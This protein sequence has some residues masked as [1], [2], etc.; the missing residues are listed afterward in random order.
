MARALRLGGYVR[1][2]RLG[3]RTLE[4]WEAGEGRRQQEDIYAYAKRQ[5]HEVVRVWE[6]PN[7]S[8]GKADRRQLREVIAAIQAG[9]IDGLVVAYISRFMRSV[10]AAFMAI[11]EIQEAGGVFMSADGQVDLTTP[12]GRFNFTV[13]MGVAELELGMKTE[14]WARRHSELIDAGVPMQVPYGYVR[15]ED[16]R[17][18][19]HPEQSPWVVRAFELRL[20]GW[21]PRKIAMH[22][23]DQG[24]PPPK[25]SA[26]WV[27]SSVH[28][29]LGRRT[30]LGEVQHGTHVKR[31]AHPALVSEV[32]FERARSVNPSR[33]GKSRDIPLVGIV[34]CAG[35]RRRL[36]GSL[37]GQSKNRPGP[38][39]VAYSCTGHTQATGCEDPI[40]YINGDDLLARLRRE[41]WAIWQRSET[42]FVAVNSNPRVVSLREDLT[43]LDGQVSRHMADDFAKE[44]DRAEWERHA[45]KLKAEKNAKGAE[46]NEA[47][48]TLNQANAPDEQSKAW[49]ED[50]EEQRRLLRSA[51]DEVFVHSDGSLT[52]Y[53]RGSQRPEVPK[54]GVRFE[55]RP[56]ERDD[57]VGVLRVAAS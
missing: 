33:M 29:M 28:T 35:C 44:F 57:Q 39:T 13:Q 2:S 4:S 41:A 11:A 50:V 52:I 19:P 49:P 6:E 25:H 15:G 8:G 3:A 7:V 36:N 48:R 22:F 51:F 18:V 34:R 12:T 46:L 21:S 1:S 30:Y 56:I 37:R 17:L 23:N 54:P 32:T 9:E 5:G 31:D 16:K 55:F 53:K 24:A 14:Q 20:E 45:L 47:L 43:I 42:K 10:P 27:H 26:R 40:R 38:G